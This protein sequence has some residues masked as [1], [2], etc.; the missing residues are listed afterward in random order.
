[1]TDKH[2]DM[3]KDEGENS[4]EVVL[5]LGELLKQ[6]REIQQ[7]SVDDVASQL[8]L[9][10]LIIRE[11]ESNDFS[12]IAS[13]TY[14]KGYVKN[15]ARFVEADKE[16]VEAALAEYF[17]VVNAPTMQSFSRKT[18][19]EAK[20]GRFMMLT[21]FIF[22]VLA[23]LLVVWWI[24]KSDMTAGIDVANITVEEAAEIAVGEEQISV[25]VL[26]VTPPEAVQDES[27]TGIE[28]EASVEEPLPVESKQVIEGIN[29]DV[30]AVIVNEEATELQTAISE[31]TSVAEIADATLRMELTDDCWIKVTDAQGKTLVNGLRI[32]GSAFDV[33]GQEPFEVILGAPQAVKLIIN[34]E[35]VDLA[36]YPTGKVARLTVKSSAGL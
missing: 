22:F 19:R 33:L 30:A 3:L 13:P 11:I 5:T 35:D 10:P 14:V 4:E 16:K 34:G 21:Y 17:P 23:V 12:N 9:R 20:E 7:L 1:M 18:T 26:D 6:A 8:H 25:E 2:I 27:Q 15:Y 28:P 36:K 32:G 31:P 24:Q 29:E